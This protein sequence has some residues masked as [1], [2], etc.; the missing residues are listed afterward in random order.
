MTRW[1]RMTCWLTLFLGGAASADIVK[2]LGF[3]QSS[4]GRD[5]DEPAWAEELVTPPALPKEADLIEFYVSAV[6][7]NRFFIDGSTLAIGKDGV[8]R[9]VLVVKTSG[10]ATNV[11]FEGIRCKT[12]EYRLYASG[13]A[14]G[15]WGLARI[16]DWR[17]IENKPVNRHHAALS[18]ELFCPQAAP[19]DSPEDGREALRR[20]KHPR[21]P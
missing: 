15:T 13:R 5:A 9:Y 2:D 3:R 18:R 19:I 4:T 7:A 11:S 8:V 10:G 14:D 6:T 17:P 16:A 1:L 20:G 21:A 12:G